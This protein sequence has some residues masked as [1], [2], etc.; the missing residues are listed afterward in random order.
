MVKDLAPSELRR[1]LVKDEPRIIDGFIEPP[2]APGLG[3]DLD[4]GVMEKFAV[5]S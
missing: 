2:E 4:Q 3:I 1:F 5:M